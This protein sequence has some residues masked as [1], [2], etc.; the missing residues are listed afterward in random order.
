MLL[1]NITKPLL[2]YS[3]RQQ[4]K[5]LQNHAQ[6]LVKRGFHDTRRPT[7]T[8]AQNRGVDQ[9][10][11]RYSLLKRLI[12]EKHEQHCD[13]DGRS[14]YS[15]NQINLGRCPIFGFD[16]DY[17]LAEYSEVLLDFIYHQASLNLVHKYGFPEDI[18]RMEYLP[19]FCIRG[20]HWDIK[21]SLL[22]KI[23]ANNIIQVC[24]RSIINCFYLWFNLIIN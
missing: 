13:V 18:V 20:L 15:V 10:K 16:Y 6:F 8:K 12:M 17:T 2:L 24:E 19:N 23:D 3:G 7:S 14:I 4:L 11:E 22:M 1:H 21:R 9:L 5:Q